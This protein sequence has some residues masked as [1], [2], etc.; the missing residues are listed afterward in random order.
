MY[1]S[2]VATPR[3]DMGRQIYRVQ[4]G[5]EPRD[6]KP[7]RSVGPGVREIRIRDDGNNYRC[8]Y[9]ANLADAV[10]VLHVFIK[11]SQKTARRDLDIAKFRLKAVLAALKIKK[12]S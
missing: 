3:Q 6:W 5:L 8:V 12:N 9:I 10:F 1:F 7:M 2:K 11:K 4:L